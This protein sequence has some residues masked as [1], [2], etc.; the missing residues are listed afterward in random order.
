MQQFT[1]I[2]LKQNKIW[3]T[4]NVVFQKMMAYIRN[5]EKPLINNNLSVYI[6]K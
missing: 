3:E 5:E 1:L 4:S 6:K 2:Q